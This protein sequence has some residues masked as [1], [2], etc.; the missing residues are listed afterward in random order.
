MFFQKF[1][2]HLLFFTFLLL[3]EMNFPAEMNFRAYKVMLNQEMAEATLDPMG[4]FLAQAREGSR[5]GD[6]EPRLV[7]TESEKEELE[8]VWGVGRL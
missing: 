5:S 4:D 1:Q 7:M 2:E 3:L 8:D 6:V